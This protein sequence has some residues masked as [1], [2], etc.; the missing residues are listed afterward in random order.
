MSAVLVHM[1]V[2]YIL[3]CI[4]RYVL[5]CEQNTKK[6]ILGWKEYIFSVA[7]IGVFS[8]VDIG[9]SNWGLELINVSL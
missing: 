1:I 5:Q 7:S 4:I 6:M 3:A 2:K 9:F 8:G